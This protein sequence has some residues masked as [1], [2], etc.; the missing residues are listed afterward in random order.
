MLL[1]RSTFKVIIDN[2]CSLSQHVVQL[3]VK[4]LNSDIWDDD[5]ELL[6]RGEWALRHRVRACRQR[7]ELQLLDTV[8]LKRIG[9]RCHWRCTMHTIVPLSSN[10]TLCVYFFVIMLYVYRICEGVHATRAGRRIQM[11]QRLLPLGRGALFICS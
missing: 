6:A 11:C 4:S 5:E 9:C 7:V 8:R 3:G 10:N 2:I 1:Y